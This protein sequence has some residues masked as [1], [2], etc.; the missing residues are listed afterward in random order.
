MYVTEFQNNVIPVSAGLYVC[1]CM[2]MRA[3]Q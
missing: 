1:A 3:G 2:Y